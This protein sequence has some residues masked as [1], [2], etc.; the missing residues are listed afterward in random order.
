MIKFPHRIIENLLGQGL[1]ILYK[2]FEGNDEFS[3]IDYIK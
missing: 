1:D 2:D 3:L